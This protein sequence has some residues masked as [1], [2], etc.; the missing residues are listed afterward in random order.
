MMK[1]LFNADY[2]NAKSAYRWR[3]K[4]GSDR[5]NERDFNK[6]TNT[7]LANLPMACSCR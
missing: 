7:T 3:T 2:R 4:P 5:L 1:H 6:R